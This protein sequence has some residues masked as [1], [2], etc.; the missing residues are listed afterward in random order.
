MRGMHHPTH[1]SLDEAETYFRSRVI[2][3]SRATAEM[4]QVAFDGQSG[5]PHPGQ[6]DGSFLFLGP[7]GVGKT[8]LVK[9]F[10][11]FKWSRDGQNWNDHLARFDMGEFAEAGSIVRFLGEQG[12]AEGLLPREILRLNRLGGGVLHID[13]V[14]K[15]HQATFAKFWL[16]LTDEGRVRDGWGRELRL[17]WITII[18]T[19]NLAGASVA[20]LPQ[21]APRAMKRRRLLASAQGYFGPEGAARFTAILTFERL[22]LEDQAAICALRAADESRRVQRDLEFKTGLP[23]E[24][25][26]AGAGVLRFLREEGYSELLGARPMRTAVQREMEHAKALLMERIRSGEIDPV[27][28]LAGGAVLGWTVRPREKAAPG[29]AARRLGL[30]VV[31]VQAGNKLVTFDP[32]LNTL[33]AA[34]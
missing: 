8:E 17:D 12:G 13:E 19:A 21:Q 5:T 29:Q 34:A 28:I 6:P 27:R 25:L 2:G 32:S 10:T 9:A 3:Q 16:G 26:P 11:R 23:L 15:A 24:I 18:M 22:E 1:H 30:E 20:R 33:A 14:E 4:A 31:E 7:T